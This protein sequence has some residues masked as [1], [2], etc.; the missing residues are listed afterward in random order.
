MLT[1]VAI[2]T[3]IFIM[4]LLGYFAVRI[5]L[6]P[7]ET[8]AGMAKIVMYFTL[9]ALIFSTLATLHAHCFG[10]QD[11]PVRPCH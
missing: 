2:T 6:V 7:G 5:N 11:Q 1:I 10:K 9:P 4:I 3:P 8:I